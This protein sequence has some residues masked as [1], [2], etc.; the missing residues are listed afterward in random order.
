MNGT[1]IDQLVQLA[2]L[3]AEFEA[4][5][6]FLDGNGRLGRILIP[7][8]LWQAKLISGPMFYMSSYLEARRDEYYERL[9]A[10]S[11][12]LDWTG[13]VKFFLDGVRIQA[14]EN[15]AKVRAI[16]QLYEDLKPVVQEST[17]SQYGIQA[18]DW[19][20]CTPIFKRPRFVKQ[21]KIPDAT[22]RRILTVLQKKGIVQELEPSRGRRA[23]LLGFM[24]LLRVTESR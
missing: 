8:F 3:H 12:D 7:L 16:R 22:A 5:H 10:V 9:L 15:L 1:A 17:H 20:F 21:S 4:L 11:R 2:V 18:L 6:P 24:E 13:W 23:G 14:E 19:L